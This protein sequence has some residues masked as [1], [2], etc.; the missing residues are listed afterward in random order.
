MSWE[1]V[2]GSGEI[3][4]CA[5]INSVIR[6][7]NESTYSVS[8]ESRQS[9][10]PLA[11]SSAYLPTEAIWSLARSAATLSQAEDSVIPSSV[12]PDASSESQPFH[13][14]WTPTMAGTYPGKSW[15]RDKGDRTFVKV[16]LARGL[17][18]H[19]RTSRF[20]PDETEGRTGVELSNDS[21]YSKPVRI[22]LCLNPLK[23]LIKPAKRRE[24]SRVLSAESGVRIPQYLSE[25]DTFLANI[26]KVWQPRVDREPATTS[27]RARI[28]FREP[29]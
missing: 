9:L 19:C 25:A 1:R 28:C 12:V 7:R 20:E 15:A 5:A 23:K 2:R 16:R 14:G 21:G 4:S 27:G 8:F 26:S 29:P 13:V 11:R 18:P 6:A 10:Q 3:F 17:K 22:E 24:W